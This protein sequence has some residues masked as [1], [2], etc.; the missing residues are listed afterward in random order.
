[1]QLFEHRIMLWENACGK[2]LPRS[3]CHCPRGLIAVGMG[4]VGDDAVQALCLALIRIRSVATWSRTTG[5]C[6]GQGSLCWGEGEEILLRGGKGTV[7]S[8]CCAALTRWFQR[9]HPP[10]AAS[11]SASEDPALPNPCPLPLAPSCASTCMTQQQEQQQH[12]MG[13]TA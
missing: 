8:G 6:H 9:R 7:L 3:L 13:W 2:E 4:W 5:P 11:P 12:N 1:M 10:P